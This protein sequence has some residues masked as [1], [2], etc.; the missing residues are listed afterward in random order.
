LQNFIHLN[1]LYIIF[2]LKLKKKKKKKKKK[3]KKKKKKNNSLRK[4]KSY[5]KR[6][7]KGGTGSFG[8]SR[9]AQ[10]NT[11]VRV[12]SPDMGNRNQLPTSGHQPQYPSINILTD[13]KPIYLYYRGNGIHTY[14]PFNQHPYNLLKVDFRYGQPHNSNVLDGQQPKNSNVLDKEATYNSFNSFNSNTRG[15]FSLLIGFYYSTNVRKYIF[16]YAHFDDKGKYKLY[17]SRFSTFRSEKSFRNIKRVGDLQGYNEVCGLMGCGGNSTEHMY[18][19]YNLIMNYLNQNPNYPNS[20]STDSSNFTRQQ[21][22]NNVRYIPNSS[23]QSP[24]TQ[25]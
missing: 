21:S 9:F 24:H 14:P 22:Y 3:T 18:A 11:P 23:G 20:V 7:P 25:Y 17:E 15:P 5:H 16:V 13:D 12:Q 19:K 4:K 6:N 10:N 2:V 8:L 1:I